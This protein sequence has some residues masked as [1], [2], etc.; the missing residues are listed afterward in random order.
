MDELTIASELLSL[1]SS[2]YSWAVV[3]ANTA[4]QVSAAIKS[5]QMSKAE[6]TEVLQD[7]IATD[8]LNA[9]ATDFDIRTRLVTVI[10]T[11]IAHI[12]TLS[13]L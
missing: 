6:A 11:L 10:S 9:E 4:L 7:L 5:G 12:S 3:R 1:A 2:T 13:A 8:K